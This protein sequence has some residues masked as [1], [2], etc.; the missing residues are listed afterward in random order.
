MPR[1]PGSSEEERVS[2]YPEGES[3]SESSRDGPPSASPGALDRR[4][5]G[6]PMS[7]PDDAR[8]SMMVFRI[9]IPRPAPD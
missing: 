5:Q 8:F 7:V 6:P 4:T 2:E 9:G 3:D 1:S